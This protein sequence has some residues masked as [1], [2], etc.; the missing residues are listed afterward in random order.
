MTMECVLSLSNQVG[1]LK[2]GVIILLVTDGPEIRKQYR[3][4]QETDKGTERSVT[5][6]HPPSLLT[7]DNTNTLLQPG[8]DSL[9]ISRNG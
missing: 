3:E 8:L 5:T 1:M 9:E 6:S 4:Y 7:N 2:R